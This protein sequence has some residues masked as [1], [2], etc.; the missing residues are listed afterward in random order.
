MATGRKTGGRSKGTPNRATLAKKL[1]ATETI[2]KAKKGG[3][4]PLDVMFA[5]MLGQTIKGKPVTDEQFQAAVAAAPYIHP[6]LASTEAK[7][8]H[9]GAID[10]GGIDAPKRAE[11]PE[12]WNARR[13]RELAAMVPA[14]GAS[15]A[16]H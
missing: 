11:T 5:R 2:E 6:R 16:R 10:T 3:V 15:V 9:S 12:E 4:L 7:V 13:E 8:N 1:A 14:A